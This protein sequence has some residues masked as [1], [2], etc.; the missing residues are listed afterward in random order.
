MCG[1][2]GVRNEDR[3]THEEVDQ[4]Q[5]PVAEVIREEMSKLPN[6]HLV[7]GIESAS[8]RAPASTIRESMRAFAINFLMQSMYIRCRVA[9]T[10]T[11]ITE[12]RAFTTLLIMRKGRWSWM[13][14]TQRVCIGTSK[15][16]RSNGCVLGRLSLADPITITS[17][18]DHG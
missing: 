4:W 15:A 14:I 7:S 2:P 10:E 8:I 16:G 12:Y 9:F 3:D 17:I 1:K 18:F 11:V 5:A 6:Q 13:K